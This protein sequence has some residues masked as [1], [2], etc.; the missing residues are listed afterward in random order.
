MKTLNFPGKLE[1]DKFVEKDISGFSWKKIG[2]IL[3]ETSGILSST[4]SVFGAN[5]RER[6]TELS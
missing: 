3:L 2:D 4:V 6:G 5:W 1:V